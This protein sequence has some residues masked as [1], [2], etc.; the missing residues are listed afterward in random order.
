M[1]D[2]D[3]YNGWSIILSIIKNQKLIKILIKGNKILIKG[4]ILYVFS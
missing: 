1:I 3:W 4:N 2:C